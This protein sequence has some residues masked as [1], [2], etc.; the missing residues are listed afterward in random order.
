MNL[1][2]WLNV[3]PSAMSAIAAGAAA[4]AAFVALSVSRKANSISEKNILAAHHHDAV[5]VLS[6][7]IDRLRKETKNLSEFSFGFWVDWPRE[8]E[9]KDERC[10]GGLD[11]RPLRHVLSNGSEM[12]ANHATRNGKR[13]RNAGRSMFS[14]IREGVND[15][16]EHEYKNL[17]KKADG[18]Y[19]K[20][21][22]TLGSPPLNKNIGE[23]DA[24]RWVCYQLTKRI[25]RD[26]LREIWRNAWLTEGWLSRYR[27]E[28]SKVKSILEEVVE[29]LRLE[30]KKIIYSVLP[31]QSN[32]ALH[33]NYEM[34]L[35]GLETLLDDGSLEL[36]ELYR[37]WK[38]D[39]DITQ[40]ILYSMAMAYW[41]FKLLDSICLD[42]ELDM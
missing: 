19:G 14:I 2:E 7:S 31:L 32:P 24:F 15:L 26:D 1:I 13:Y 8:I 9:L 42:D 3:I 16:N 23:A 39:E 38:H 17:L 28:F 11:P 12:L 27:T 34:V 30:K 20:F 25:N 35:S 22:C 5:S 33:K 29:S 40:L 4:C 18:T 21:E 10:K 36:L 6:K 37:E 41:V